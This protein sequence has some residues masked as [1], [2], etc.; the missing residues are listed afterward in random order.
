[1]DQGQEF[2]ILLTDL[3]NVFDFLPHYLIIAKLF[4]YGFGDKALLFT[5]DYL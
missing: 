5:Y 2:V 4:A 3:S 1:M